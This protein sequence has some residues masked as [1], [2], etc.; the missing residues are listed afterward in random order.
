MNSIQGTSTLP[1]IAL[2][3]KYLNFSK[4]CQKADKSKN[5]IQVL[6]YQLAL[7]VARGQINILL[8]GPL[9]IF[10]DN[11]ASVQYIIDYENKASM[12]PF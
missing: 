7:F 2:L 12:G 3:L 6:R 8:L 10:L 4:R 9:P 11:A 5:N 1:L